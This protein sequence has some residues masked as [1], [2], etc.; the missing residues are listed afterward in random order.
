MTYI[1][2]VLKNYQELEPEM[3]LKLERIIIIEN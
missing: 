1:R 2:T 3:H